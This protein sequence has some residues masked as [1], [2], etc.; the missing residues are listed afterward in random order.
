VSSNDTKDRS[1]ND[2]ASYATSKSKRKILPTDIERGQ[3]NGKI[4]LKTRPNREI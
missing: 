3:K 2:L 4:Y 1:S